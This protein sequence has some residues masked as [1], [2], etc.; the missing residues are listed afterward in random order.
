MGVVPV[1][2]EAVVIVAEHTWLNVVYRRVQVGHAAE[3]LR[4][5]AAVFRT[6]FDETAG[7][8]NRLDQRPGSIGVL[9][10]ER[11]RAAQDFL[12]VIRPYRLAGSHREALALR[13]GV[14]RPRFADTKAVDAPGA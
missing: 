5:A 13:D 11:A 1:I 14:G 12:G 8:Q 2:A 9:L 4:C 3:Q 6:L 10:D 7:G